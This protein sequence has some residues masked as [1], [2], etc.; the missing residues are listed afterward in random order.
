M[1]ESVR[2]Q[3]LDKFYTLGPIAQQCIDTLMEILPINNFD[4]VIEP[5]AGN[6]SFYH[7]LPT[8]NKIG[9]DIS[10]EDDA[11][12]QMDFFDYM[13]DH[14]EQRILVIGNPP[15][16][17]VS[18]LAVKFFNHAA[19]WADVIAF[20]I[21]KTFRKVSIQNRLAMNF[22]LLLDIDIPHKPCSFDPPMGVKCC[23][24]IWQKQKSLRVAISLPATHPDWVFLPYGPK[25]ENNQPTPPINA[26]FAIRAY[27]GECGY[28]QTTNLDILR[29]KS[30]HFI[31]ANIDVFV[32]I[33]RFNQ[34]NYAESMNTARQNSIGKKELVQLYTIGVQIDGK[35]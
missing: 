28:I 27:G 19:Q 23:F 5:S 20:I 2:S 4:I 1:A 7:R 10:P 22:H 12:I 29:P 9:I 26:D 30:W 18:S 32:L 11:I 25:D 14:I 34:L 15:F 35:L 8:I 33:H 17:R 31:K 6:G 3:G 13:P 24:Q 21:P 16:G